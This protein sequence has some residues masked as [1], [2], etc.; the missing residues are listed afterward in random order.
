MNSTRRFWTELLIRF[1]GAVVLTVFGLF[2]G[3]LYGEIE[4]K[5]FVTMLFATYVIIVTLFC[6]FIEYRR[7]RQLELV[8]K[9][10]L[11]ISTREG[12]LLCDAAQKATDVLK[13]ITYRYSEIRPQPS[14]DRPH[15]W[16]YQQKRSILQAICDVLR[17]DTREYQGAS[18]YFKATLF[19]VVSRDKLVLDSCYYPPGVQPRT[20]SIDRQ[21]HPRAT[22]FSCLDTEDM[23]VVP[24]V[25]EEVQKGADAMWVEL[26]PGQ[27]RQYGSMVCVAVSVGER[28][29]HTFGVIAILTVDTNRLDYFSREQKEK[30]FLAILLAP[31]RQ[32]LS[33][34]YLA[35]GDNPVGEPDGKE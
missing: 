12:S 17:R 10:N 13:D 1:T 30:N 5:A 9:A 29:T 15:G 19:R 6:G 27:S 20:E 3:I 21:S 31:F 23:Q 28:A 18:D 16:A 4:S 33:F 32:Q 35:E 26:Y 14:L 34:V 2:L 22:A 24:N 25:P 7:H 11:L 8:E